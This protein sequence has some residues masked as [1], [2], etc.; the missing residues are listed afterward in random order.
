[1]YNEVSSVGLSAERGFYT[2]RTGRALSVNRNLEDSESR[3][4]RQEP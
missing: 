2:L 3:D 4:H 1:M